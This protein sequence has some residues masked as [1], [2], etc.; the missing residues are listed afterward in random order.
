[1]VEASIILLNVIEMPP[2]RSTGTFTDPLEG[3][4][5]LT[6]GGVLSGGGT[7]PLRP[8]AVSDNAAA[9]TTAN[10][11]DSFFTPV[12]PFTYVQEELPVN[13]HQIG[14][15]SARI[16]SKTLFDF[17]HG[18]VIITVGPEHIV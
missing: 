16:S 8:H 9:R 3:M 4:V 12:A 7:G 1:M 5:E 11:T 13:M 2:G 17:H 18:T 10:S 15:K 6:V 14:R